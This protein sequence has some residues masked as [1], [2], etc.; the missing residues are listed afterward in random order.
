MVSINQITGEWQVYVTW[1]ST[2]MLWG[3]KRRG[4]L[5]RGGE[6]RWHKRQSQMVEEADGSG[7]AEC[8][9]E[10]RQ[11]MSEVTGWHRGCRW[12]NAR[13]LWGGRRRDGA[14]RKRERGG[15]QARTPASP[16]IDQTAGD[17]PL[18]QTIHTAT[19]RVR[20][21]LENPSEQT[22]PGKVRS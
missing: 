20:E 13:R 22:K 8:E 5:E 11:H 18:P 2:V 9:V 7:R 19:A 15:A 3:R 4:L 16:P 14:G 21:K 10:F 17:A 1:G 6:V 12:R